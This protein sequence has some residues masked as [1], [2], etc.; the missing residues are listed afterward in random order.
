[1]HREYWQ[2]ADPRAGTA[3]DRAGVVRSGRDLESLGGRGDHVGEVRFVIMGLLSAN[4]PAV[5]TPFACFVLACTS[6]YTRPSSRPSIPRH[7]LSRVRSTRYSCRQG[8]QSPCPRQDFIR[9]PSAGGC[10]K[11]AG[12]RDCRGEVSPNPTRNP[13][14]PRSPRGSRKDR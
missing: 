8:R 9:I 11:G 14:S 5:F 1:M 7:R 4:F 2:A 3:A 13:A 12:S 6:I 10:Q